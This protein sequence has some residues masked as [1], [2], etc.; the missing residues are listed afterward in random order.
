VVAHCRVDR[1]PW[2]KVPYTLLQP[3]QS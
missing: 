2:I 1:L 3:P